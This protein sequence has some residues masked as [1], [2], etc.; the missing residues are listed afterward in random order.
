M[1]EVQKIIADINN[2]IISPIYFLS[3][4]EPFFIDQISN[5]IEKNLLTETEQAF[6]QMVIYGKDVDIDTL[7]HY[8]KEFPMMAQRRVIIVKEAQNLSRV[9]DNLLPYAQNPTPTTI[10]VFCYK[11][12]KLDSRKKIT[13]ELKKYVFFESKPLY[14]NEVERWIPTFLKEKN[15]TITNVATR[16]LVEYL[17]N[18]L[19][20]IDNELNKLSIILAPQ[21]QITPDVIEKNIGISKQFNNFELQKALGT[22][23]ELKA[24]Q[25]IHYFSENP[26]ENPLVLIVASLYNFFE[27]L[28]IYHAT[29]PK[30]EAELVK[31][32][33]VNP[34]FLNDYHQAAQNYPMKKVSQVIASI[35]QCDTKSKGVASGSISYEYILKEL[36][37]SILR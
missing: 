9:I 15:Y 1:N 7:I 27:K 26:K 4:D 3:G 22:K 33:K 11:Y 13:K 29:E 5:H 28:L 30:T 31:N 16:M 18:N 24:L 20:R 14:E 35:R 37:I 12:A 2:G 23:N 21:S 32:L 6:N 17:G 34:Y 10:L 25:I 36:I 19:S 8:A